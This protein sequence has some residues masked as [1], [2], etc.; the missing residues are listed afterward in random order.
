MTVCSESKRMLYVKCVNSM[1]SIVTAAIF[2]GVNRLAG[3]F[4]L[5]S[6]HWIFSLYVIFM[7]YLISFLFNVIINVFCRISDKHLKH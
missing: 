3:N 6:K 1:K 4:L 5:A 7:F 2:W